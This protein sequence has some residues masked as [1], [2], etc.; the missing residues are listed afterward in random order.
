MTVILI[1]KMKMMVFRMLIMSMLMATAFTRGD[2][3]ILN[4]QSLKK[5]PDRHPTGTLHG[6]ARK[7]KRL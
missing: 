2:F 3:S 1:I 5:L 7:L 4:K 6:P